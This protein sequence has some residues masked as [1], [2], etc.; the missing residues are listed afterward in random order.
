LLEQLFK[1]TVLLYTTDQ[2]LGESFWFEIVKNYSEK[3]RYNHT[4][5]HLENLLTELRAVKN[6]ISDWDAVV[7]ALS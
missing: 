2:D 4:L 6:I 1:S 3:K 7:F 5:S